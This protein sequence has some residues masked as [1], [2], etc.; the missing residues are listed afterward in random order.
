MEDMNAS[1]KDGRFLGS[2]HLDADPLV[3]KTQSE[4]KGRKYT[5]HP[6]E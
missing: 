5:D 1:G 4:G 6:D 2:D 3:N